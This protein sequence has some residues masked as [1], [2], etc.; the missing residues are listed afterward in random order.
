MAQKKTNNPINPKDVA[1]SKLLVLLIMSFAYIFIL[2]FL[3]KYIVNTQT[4]LT[5]FLGIKI[6]FYTSIVLLAASI[7]YFIVQ[8]NKKIDEKLKVITS[9]NILVTAVVFFIASSLIFKYDV[10]AI[11]LM[12]AVVPA[13]FV[14]YLIYTSYVRDFFF[15]SVGCV[16]GSGILFLADK[17]LSTV[18]VNKI[19]AGSLT[20][21]LGALNSVYIPLVIIFLFIGV[22][23]LLAIKMAQKNRGNVKVGKNI[24]KI[25]SS[26]AKWSLMYITIII[27][28]VC[29]IIST[30]YSQIALYG[31]Y[32][33]GAYFVCMFV[34]YTYKLMN[35]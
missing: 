2:M 9:K 32:I 25:A 8:K 21:I 19:A 11:K 22:V 29:L 7:V 31:I 4:I 17:I 12:Y 6:Q 26:H 14:L 1:S 10:N 16:I 20:Y 5:G 15:I 3:Y 28:M 13:W 27:P 18:V 23:F 33:I 30:F 34:Y 24:I 35:K